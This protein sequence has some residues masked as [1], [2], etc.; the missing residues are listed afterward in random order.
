MIPSMAAVRQAMMLVEQACAGT[1]EE[2]AR[3]LVNQAVVNPTRTVEVVL[4]LAD[5]V[6]ASRP[7]ELPTDDVSYERYL[8]R[9]HAAFGRGERLEWV[10]TGER[11]Y[12][13][14]RKQRV[15]KGAA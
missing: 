5:M 9:A 12:Q 6:A 2:R 13:R 10:T 15:R 8:K 11:E 4:A 3:D 14:L 1:V 7:P